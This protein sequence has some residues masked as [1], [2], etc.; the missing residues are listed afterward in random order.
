MGDRKKLPGDIKK[1]K[2]PPGLVLN[3][4]DAWHDNGAHVVGDLS[5][6]R[7]LMTFQQLQSQF[8]IPKE[9][10]VF[11]RSAILSDQKINL[12]QTQSCTMMWRGS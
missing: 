1:E 2:F 12:L 4:F 11:S 8:R 6:D 3:K 9:H 5:H 7:A 10:L